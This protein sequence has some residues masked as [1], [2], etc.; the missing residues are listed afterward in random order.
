MHICM[1]AHRPIYIY[2]SRLVNAVSVSGCSPKHR[3]GWLKAYLILCIRL[4]YMFTD[5]LQ[6]QFVKK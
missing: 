2:V 3:T 5:A 4:A 6:M 1:Y